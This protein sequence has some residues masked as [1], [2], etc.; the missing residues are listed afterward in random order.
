MVEIFLSPSDR[1]LLAGTIPCSSPYKSRRAGKEGFRSQDDTARV[2]PLHMRNA[3]I[4]VML[5]AYISAFPTGC[6]YSLILNQISIFLSLKIAT[7]VN[8]GADHHSPDH[9]IWK[10]RPAAFNQ[11]FSEDG[12]R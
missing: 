2:K 12:I 11:F 1:P 4:A 5:L 8:N 9:R 7:M 6:I 3:F 10:W